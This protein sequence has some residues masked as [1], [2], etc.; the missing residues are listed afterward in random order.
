MR[1]VYIVWRVFETKIVKDV[2]VFT[3]PMYL[4]INSETGFIL[5]RRKD[6]S[7]A[8]MLAMGM[9]DTLAALRSVS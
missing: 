5:F 9:N 7:D 4:V 2:P 1:P 6:K 3:A 8:D